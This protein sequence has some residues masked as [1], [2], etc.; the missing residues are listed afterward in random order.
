MHKHF[1][2]C[3]LYFVE[4]VSKRCS[5]LSLYI[6]FSIFLVFGVIFDQPIPARSSIGYICNSRYYH[7]Q[8]G[9]IR[10][11]IVVII[12]CSSVSEVVINPFQL[13][14]Q[15]GIFVT[16]VIIIIK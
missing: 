12:F 2:S 6:T 8:I 14:A 5:Q 4:S 13:E 7:N 11:H 10:F 15:L 16:H 3:W 1:I 9:S